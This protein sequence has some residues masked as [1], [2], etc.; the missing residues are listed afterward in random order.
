ML[1]QVFECIY[2]IQMMEERQTTIALGGGGITKLVNPDLTL[3]RVVNAKCPA[4]YARQIET[5][6]PAKIDQIRKH[7]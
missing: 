7:C 2:N 5:D 3:I 6:L 1:G 4:T